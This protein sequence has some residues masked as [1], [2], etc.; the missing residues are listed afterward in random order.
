MQYTH[1]IIKGIAHANMLPKGTSL[2][3][4]GGGTRGFFSAGVFEA[5]MDEGIMFPYILGISA[6]AANAMSYIAGQRG[7]NRQI[8]AQYISHKD[9]VSFRNLFKVKSLF[10]YD[11]IFKTIPQNHVFWDEEIF[12]ATDTRFIIGTIDIN[13]GKSCWFEKDEIDLSDCINTLIAACSLPL[14]SEIVHYGGKE[15]MD[16]GISDPIPI[17][18][19]IADGNDFHVVVLT[20][21]MGYRKAPFKFKGLMK[22]F[23][24]KYPH[25]I[26][27][28]VNRHII[29]NRQL[30]LCEKLAQEGKAIIIRPQT[31]LSLGRSATDTNKLLQLYDEG[32][33]EGK[34]AVDKLKAAGI[35]V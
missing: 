21:N 18:K 19:A 23:Y 1:E 30:A 22:L 3:L 20:R 35:F 5:F 15:L 25:F 29:Y 33:D 4:E 11:Y 14:L 6:G 27:A 9:Y 16:G 12:N 28:V 32:H 24:K 34:K 13:T 26:D 8:V 31:P 2:V 10:G 17:E 7:R